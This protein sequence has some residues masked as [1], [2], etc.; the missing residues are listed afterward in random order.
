MTDNGLAGFALVAR[1]LGDQAEGAYFVGGCVRDL[2]LGQP[3]ADVDLALPLNPIEFGPTLGRRL[4][5]HAFVMDEAE[6]VVRI[7]VKGPPKLQ[8]DLSPLKGTIATDL[9]SRDLTI[10]AMAIPAGASWD[11]LSEGDTHW[12]SRLI[13][14]TGGRDDL[15]QG[16]IRFVTPDSPVADALRTLR[17]VRFRWRLR[18]RYAPGT[19][20]RIRECAPGLWRVSSER[21]RDEVFGALRSGEP[22]AVFSD[23]ARLE[24]LARS[25]GLPSAL[26][27]ADW[28]AVAER[29]GEMTRGLSAAIRLISEGGARHAE[30][31]LKREGGPGRSRMEILQ[32]STLPWLVG[33]DV[34]AAS[35]RM[36]LSA[37]EVRLAGQATSAIGSLAKLRASATLRPSDALRVVRKHAAFELEAVLMACSVNPGE[38]NDARMIDWA[39]ERRLHPPAP[40]LDGRAVGD[41]LGLAPGPEI[42]RALRELEEAQA[43]GLIESPEDAIE[44]LKQWRRG[45]SGAL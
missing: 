27:G 23:L 17:A 12:S 20:R 26:G 1:A 3:A 40:L 44:W 10:N 24:L 34:P 38:V 36:A 7:A 9:A 22:A 41:A 6:R 2:W 30:S 32:W 37:D 4:G 25:A 8:V 45:G 29:A 11:G 16:L 19:E 35:R 14:P 39:L 28:S 31:E 5:G 21:V 18:A 15:H 43:D 13:D 33:E 42:G